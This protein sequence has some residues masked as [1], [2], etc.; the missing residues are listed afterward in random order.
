MQLALANYMVSLESKQVRILYLQINALPI[1]S[2]IS[3]NFSW[4]VRNRQ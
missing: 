4:A 2:V 1:T 3:P